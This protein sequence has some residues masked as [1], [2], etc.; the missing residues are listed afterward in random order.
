MN[1]IAEQLRAFRKPL[2]R[3]DERFHALLVECFGHRAGDA[4]YWADHRYPDDVREAAVKYKLC[5]WYVDQLTA[6]NRGEMPPR[7]I[8]TKEAA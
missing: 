7:T 5:C 8:Q 3:A 1:I 6:W 2:V 4:R